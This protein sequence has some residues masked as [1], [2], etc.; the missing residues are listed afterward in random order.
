MNNLTK[1]IDDRTILY[2][3]G[4]R[5]NNNKYIVI[6]MEQLNE[7]HNMI[8]IHLKSHENG[9]ILFKSEYSLLIIEYCEENNLMQ[10]SIKLDKLK[11]YIIYLYNKNYLK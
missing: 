1:M 5:I 9:V 10:H 11:K 2:T 4:L 3:N 7:Q 6:N 8:Y